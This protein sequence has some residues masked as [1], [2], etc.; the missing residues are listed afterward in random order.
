[1]R[2]YRLVL[3]ILGLADLG[4]QPASARELGRIEWTEL[5]IL[6]RRWAIKLASV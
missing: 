2:G 6:L 5:R 4:G 1:M 3:G